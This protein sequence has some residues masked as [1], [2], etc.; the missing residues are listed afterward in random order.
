MCIAR[1]WSRISRSTGRS[2]GA[3]PTKRP[4]C[5]CSAWREQRR[6]RPRRLSIDRR[7]DRTGPGARE[8]HRRG[9]ARATR[10]RESRSFARLAS[11]ALAPPWCRTLSFRKILLRPPSG[12]RGWA[13]SIE[14]VRSIGGLVAVTRRDLQLRDAVPQP[15]GG[16][17]LAG[18]AVTSGRARRR[19]PRSVANN[20]RFLILPWVTAP[21]LASHTSGRMAIPRYLLSRGKTTG[22]GN[23]P[24]SDAPNR[25]I[26][27]VLS[28]PVAN[29]GRDSN[30]AW[31]HRRCWEDRS[32][33]TDPGVHRRHSRTEAAKHTKKRTPLDQGQ[34]CG[35][36][37]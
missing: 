23:P 30:A 29:R 36:T 37:A 14:G 31:S 7:P 2:R 18:R 32:S 34:S 16:T 3:Y 13:I 9:G 20:A 4:L 26:N 28:A 1:A 33:L 12:L 22:G 25:S 5:V 6:R 27:A 35:G 24:G 8:V 21:H 17:S 11:R 10:M 15:D 19:L